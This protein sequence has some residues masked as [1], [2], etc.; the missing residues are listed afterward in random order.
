M[1][2]FSKKNIKKYKNIKILIDLSNKV[3]IIY[4]TYIINLDIYTEKI[5]FN[6]QKIEKLF[7]NTIKIVILDCLIKNKFKK[8]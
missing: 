3:N 6:I 8:I 2:E 7:L 1:I 4:F 5:N